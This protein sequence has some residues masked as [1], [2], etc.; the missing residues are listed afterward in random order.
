MRICIVALELQRALPTRRVGC[1]LGPC[2]L[3]LAALE[4]RSGARDQPLEAIGLVKLQQGL[5]LGLLAL[6]V[7]HGLG[8]GPLGQMVTQVA[9]DSDGD[10]LG[11]HGQPLQAASQILSNDA[12]D[13]LLVRQN[14]V[15]TAILL[16]PFDSCF[17]AHL[18]HAWHIVHAVAHQG[19]VVDHLL[20]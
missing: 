19:L 20:G 16:Q 2:A 8:I 11:G 4:L 13:L 1:P 14:A 12:G 5:G 15:Q 18:G 3:A 6:Q 9:I 17:G 7:S 10:E